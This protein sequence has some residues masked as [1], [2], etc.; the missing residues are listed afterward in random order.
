M[1]IKFLIPVILLCLFFAAC[2]K[3]DIDNKPPVVNAGNDT[4]FVLK[5][6]LTDTINLKGSA[7]DPDGT[8][9]GYTW[10]QISG[11]T[12]AKILYPGSASTKVTNVITGSYVFQ[13]MATDDQGATGVKTITVTLQAPPIVN[14]T[15]QPNQ[16]TQEVDLTVW[17]TVDESD[18]T[19]PEFGAVAWTHN[20]DPAYLR[21][22][23]RFD[24]SSISSTATII[25]AKL[26]LYSTPNPINGNQVDANSG[27]NNSMYIQRVTSAW[28]STV[29][30][31]NQPGTVTTSQVSVSSTTQSKLDLVDLDVTNLVKDMQQ[32]GNYGFMIKLQNETIYNS[33]IFCSSKHSDVTK[34][35]KLIIQYSN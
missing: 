18:E 19:A 11:P 5:S 30:W 15:L 26:S 8:V 9:V 3:D 2:Q 33:R 13:L 22:L 24:L 1:R 6:S 29:T 25:S 14:L 34:H 27:T 23:L 35:P 32:F 17:G 10:T 20:G 21:G 31:Q 7:V 16:N 12:S 4:T 28:T